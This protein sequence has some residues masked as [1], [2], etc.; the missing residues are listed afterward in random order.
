MKDSSNKGESSEPPA[1]NWETALKTAILIGLSIEQFNYMTPYEF[2]LHC[3]AYYE[4]KENESKEKLT[5]VWLG[6]YY[7]RTKK[8]PKLK[9]EL[10]KITGEKQRVMSDDEMLQMVKRL[11][12]QFGGTVSKGGV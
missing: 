5:L 3:E 1:W 10:K 12:S 2:A 11:N 8:L 4:L 7:H 9:D 6:E